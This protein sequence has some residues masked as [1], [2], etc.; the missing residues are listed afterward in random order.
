MLLRQGSLS[1]AQPAD[2]VHVRVELSTIRPGTAVGGLD[3]V[4]WEGNFLHVF[5][6]GKAGEMRRIVA[7]EPF[8]NG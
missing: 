7:V 6:V 3:P 8:G 2:P 5:S 1:A 4:L